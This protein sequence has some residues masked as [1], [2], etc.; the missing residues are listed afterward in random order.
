MKRCVRQSIVRRIRVVSFV[1]GIF[2]TFVY[3]QLSA[4]QPLIRYGRVDRKR[5][6]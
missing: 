2:L 3:N 6:D 5:V 4:C 1:C